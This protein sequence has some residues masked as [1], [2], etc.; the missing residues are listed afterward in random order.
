[1][2][3]LDASEAYTRRDYQ[4]AANLARSVTSISPRSVA[5]WNL[6]GISLLE[7]HDLDAAATALETEVRLDAASSFGYNNLGRVYWQQRKYDEAIAQFQK[8]IFSDAMGSE[9][10]TSC[11][12]S[13]LRAAR[14]A[15]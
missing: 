15:R 11:C 12:C 6:L 4:T 13:R 2:Q 5:A 14:I 7:L 10:V 8:Q 1:M 3:G 9:Q